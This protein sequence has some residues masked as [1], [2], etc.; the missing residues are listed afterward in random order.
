MAETQFGGPNA[1][2]PVSRKPDGRCQLN[3]LSPDRQAAVADYAAG[4]TLSETA[5]W[6]KNLG[7]AP[8]PGATTQAG[9]GDTLSP[10]DDPQDTAIS[11]SALARWLP[12][13]RMRQE[14]AQNHDSVGALIQ[15][16]RSANPAWTPGEVHQAA[17]T[18]FEA[19][20][21]QRHE[22]RLW[23]LTQ[24][25]D[26]R[27]AQLALATAKNKQSQ[28]SKLKLGLEV[29]AQGFRVHPE[30]RELFEQACKIIEPECPP[31]E[32]PKS[33]DPR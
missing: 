5:E 3:R 25:L 33:T 32:T 7:W 19:L 15:H 31:Q 4:H 9:P 24:R 11:R 30:A 26:L 6:L 10:P 23:A 16:L 8:E 14:C 12:G 18:F 28:Q 29:I 22:T 27:R 1:Q 2:E 20:A 17:Q 13:Y 21:I